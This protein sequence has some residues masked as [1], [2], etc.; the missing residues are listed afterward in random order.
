MVS[1]GR[2]T[3]NAFR[4]RNSLKEYGMKYVYRNRKESNNITAITARQ[5]GY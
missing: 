1:V 4:L 2:A 5:S 3:E